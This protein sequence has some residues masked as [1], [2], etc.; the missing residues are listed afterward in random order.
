MCS[1]VHWLPS[2]RRQAQRYVPRAG[3]S[4][5]VWLVA[6]KG[7]DGQ[8][9]AWMDGVPPIRRGRRLRSFV[10]PLRALGIYRQRWKSET[11]ISV[12][13]RKLEDGVQSRLGW[14]ARQELVV[15]ELVYNLYR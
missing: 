8:T 15:K 2:L 10:R 11:V 9:V 6:D 4:A 13:K 5:R 14:L 3:R 12:I 7:F 1:E